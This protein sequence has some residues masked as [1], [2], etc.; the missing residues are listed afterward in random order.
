[1]IAQSP[2]RQ[3]LSLIFIASGSLLACTIKGGDGGGGGA[4]TDGDNCNAGNGGNGGA[5]I[6][7][8]KY[9]G[10]SG[11]EGGGGGR[12]SNGAGFTC[13]DGYGNSRCR[14]NPSPLGSGCFCFGL[15]NGF[16][17]R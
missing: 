9:Q 12:S 13:C 16:V 17:C 8:T 4:C 14:I 2:L 5:A 6:Q 10:G 1:M 7:V 11:G 15:G 3:G